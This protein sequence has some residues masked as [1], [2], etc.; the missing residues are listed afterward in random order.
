[1]LKL[2]LTLTPS[3]S[4]SL[5][6]I[7]LLEGPYKIALVRALNKTARWAKAQLATEVAAELQVPIR[8]VRQHLMIQGARASKPEM[9]LGLSPKG[10][11]LNAKTLG[12]PVQSA[13]GVRIRRRHFDHAFIAQMPTGHR[14]VFRRQ[15]KARLP[16]Q[17]VQLVV[18][19]KMQKAMTRLLNQTLFAQFE[20]LLAREIRYLERH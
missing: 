13:Q 3:I 2:A 15:G 6:H 4:Q 11:V 8:S 14:G 9:Q 12:K 20:R 18:T 7:Q 16:I 10:T 5:Q 19:G 1:M 17:S